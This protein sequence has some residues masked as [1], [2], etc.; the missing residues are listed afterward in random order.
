MFLLETIRTQL[1]YDNLK[2]VS[3]QSNHTFESFLVAHYTNQFF[4]L[5][6]E[7]NNDPPH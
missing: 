5:V 1:S 7:K 4:Q 3:R 2:Q 6:V